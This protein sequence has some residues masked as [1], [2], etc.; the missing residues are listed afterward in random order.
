[1]HYEYLSSIEY[2]NNCEIVKLIKVFLKLLKQPKLSFY[3]L[4]VSSE[5]MAWLVVSN[6]VIPKNMQKSI[7]QPH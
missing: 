2:N 3:E 4:H 7:L 6:R 1:M 5:E